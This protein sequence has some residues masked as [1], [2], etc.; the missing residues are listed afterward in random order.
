MDNLTNLFLGAFAY[1]SLLGFL[2]KAWAMNN[3]WGWDGVGWDPGAP[4]DALGRGSRESSGWRSRNSGECSW[5][6]LQEKQAL[7]GMLCPEAPGNPGDALGRDSRN[8]KGREGGS[9]AGEGGKEG[10]KEEPTAGPVPV[11]AV[12]VPCVV[13]ARAHNGLKAPLCSGCGRAAF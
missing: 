5:K 6:G 4:E 13:P 10:G 3:G 2:I 9:W 8:S 1:S 12:A 7:Q 11:P